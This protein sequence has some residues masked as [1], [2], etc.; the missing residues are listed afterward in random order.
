M[1]NCRLYNVSHRE[2]IKAKAFIVSLS[3][4]TFSIEIKVNLYEPF[5]PKDIL[6]MQRR[7]LLVIRL[8]TAQ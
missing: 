1:R 7:V 5:K 3:H 8:L 2:S 6:P 4:I